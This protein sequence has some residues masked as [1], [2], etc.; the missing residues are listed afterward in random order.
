MFWMPESAI[1]IMNP[2]TGRRYASADAAPSCCRA[3]ARGGAMT[4]PSR[5]SGWLRTT[6]DEHVLVGHRLIVKLGAAV[7]FG[8]KRGDKPQRGTPADGRFLSAVGRRL[9]RTLLLDENDLCCRCLQTPAM[10][11]ALL[12]RT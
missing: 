5:C 3:R 7:R 2:M 4:S 8:W 11:E 9:E 12:E 10:V 1:A 6:Y